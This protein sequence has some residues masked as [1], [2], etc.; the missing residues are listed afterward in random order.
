MFL[1][2]AFSG[3]FTSEAG[4][5]VQLND[6][7]SPSRFRYPCYH[8]QSIQSILWVTFI[9]EWQPH[10]VKPSQTAYLDCDEKDREAPK[11]AANHFI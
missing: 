9:I 11:K 2:F 10:T 3:N 5:F 1:R 8:L 4:K 6:N 7:A